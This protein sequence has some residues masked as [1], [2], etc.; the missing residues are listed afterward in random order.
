MIRNVIPVIVIVDNM[1]DPEENYIEGMEMEEEVFLEGLQ[2]KKSLAELEKEYSKKVKEIRRIYE[3]SLK[4]EMQEEK[5]KEIRKIKMKRFI[6]GKEEKEFRVEGINLEESKKDRKKR[7]RE[8][9]RYRRKRHFIEIREK[10]IPNSALYSYYRTKRVA[11]DSSKNVFRFLGRIWEK[12]SK[13]VGDIFSLIKEG[14]T[15]IKKETKRAINFLIT[16]FSKKKK[17]G[18]EGEKEAPAPKDGK[19]DKK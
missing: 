6:P 19:K 14:F 1:E 5:E 2:N 15:K 18:K 17:Q 8:L 12:I 16:K 9:A 10:K 11:K 3:K 4:K 7:E 13:K